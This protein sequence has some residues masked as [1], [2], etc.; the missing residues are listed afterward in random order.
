MRLLLGVRYLD[1]VLLSISVSLL[2][3]CPSD[4]GGNGGADTPGADTDAGE[5][6]SVGDADTSSG[7]DADTV[8]DTPTQ[9]TSEDIPL[10]DAPGTIAVT[11]LIA[12]ENP[13]NVLSFFVE[14]R[15]DTATASRL[16]VTCGSYYDESFRDAGPRTEHEAFVMGLRASTN[17]VFEASAIDDNGGLS[18]A[19]TN[20]QVAELPDWLP[21]LTATYDD[22]SDIQTGWSM[23]NLHSEVSQIPPS[24]AIVDRDGQFRWYY[25][26]P[27]QDFHIDNDVRTV[28]EGVMMQVPSQI[29]DW[30]GEVVWSE[31]LPAHHDM[32]PYGNDDHIM[33]L[34]MTTD[35][36]D[37]VGADVVIEYD[38]SSGEN[39]W[40]WSICEHYTPHENLEDWSHLNTIEPFPGENALLLSSRVQHAMFKVN[41]DTEEVVWRLGARGDFEMSQE[42]RF[43]NQHAPEILENGNILVFDNGNDG[44]RRYSRAIEIQYTDTGDSWEAEVVWEYT[45]SPHI[46]C[47][48]WGDADE[49]PN[50]NRLISFGVEFPADGDSHLIEVTSDSPAEVVWDLEFPNG[51][52][53]YR[54][55]RIVNPETGY[56]VTDAD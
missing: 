14:W 48:S 8:P 55:E 40:E 41:M 24:V 44:D 30:E 52:S 33:F 28:S 12:V 38:R 42:D 20:I 54:A 16:D 26:G 5:T 47:F 18:S 1:S 2:L 27:G 4:N 6:D 29:I 36:P 19:T 50:G 15:T 39:V 45:P 32:R 9:D 35:C 21:E 53:M 23:F 17:C 43:Y 3:G 31:G 46:F 37:G 49:Q 34:S 56:I 22:A 25:R 10:S 11:N 13:D 51:W 7:N